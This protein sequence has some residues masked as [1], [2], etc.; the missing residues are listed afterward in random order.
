MENEDES[1]P[2]GT[3]GTIQSG[4]WQERLG[5]IGRTTGLGATPDFTNHLTD[6]L[7]EKLD[8]FRIHLRKD[9]PVNMLPME[10]TLKPDAQP[11]RYRARRY[12]KVHREL[13]SARRRVSCSGFMLQKLQESL[14]LG[15]THC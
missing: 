6:L 1:Y 9:P 4:F 15:T 12:F 11:V 7:K 10:I 13:L 14:V 3:S 8:V 5:K 2:P